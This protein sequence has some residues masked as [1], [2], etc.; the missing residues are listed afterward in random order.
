M[1]NV[2][3]NN[4]RNNNSAKTTNQKYADGISNL[5]NTFSKSMGADSAGNA[6]AIMNLIKFIL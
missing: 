2:S 3:N 1:F 6:S 5:L 4:N